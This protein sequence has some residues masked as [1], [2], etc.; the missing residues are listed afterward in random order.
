MIETLQPVLILL[1]CGI[2]SVLLLPRIGVSPIVGFLVAGMVLGH[3]G[4]GLIPHND[5]IHLLAE[6]GVVFLLFDIGLHFSLRH[7]KQE[8]KGIFLLGPLQVFITAG[9]FYLIG[10]A[11]SLPSDVNLVMSIALALSSTAVVSQVLKDRGIEGTPNSNTA[12]AILVFQDICAIFLLILAD[13]IGG[14]GGME[15]AVE[16]GAAVIK[17]ILCFFAALFIGKYILNPF[18]GRLIRFNNSEVF[19][20][21]ALFL[22]LLTGTATGAIGLSLTLGAFLAGMIISETPFKHIIQTELRPF[23]FLLLSFFFLTVGALIDIHI[24]IEQW[25]MVLAATAVLV[26]V[27]FGAIF[28][29]FKVLRG[30]T[31]NAILQSTLLFQGSEF[32]FVV[33]AAPAVAAALDSTMI[34]VL[35]AAVAL[36]MALTT[37]VYDWFA[38]HICPYVV[39]RE[40][41]KKAADTQEQE[42]AQE[43]PSMI[44][45]G[46]DDAGHTLARALHHFEIPYIA[47]DQEYRNFLKARLGGFSVL[48]GDKADV[49]FWENLGIHNYQYL[50]ISAPNMQLAQLYEPIARER[51]PHLIRHVVVFDQSDYDEYVEKTTIM[52]TMTYGVPPGLELAEKVLHDIGVDCEEIVSWMAKEQKLHLDKSKPN[53]GRVDIPE[54]LQEQAA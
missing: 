9:I 38:K 5:T 16:T 18:F 53:K 42:Q 48:Y 12:M 41:A 25:Y 22:V 30:R 51:F 8:W 50:L 1:G 7:I 32:L 3:H 13:S 49:R 17:C 45:L 40:N 21:I 36:S 31:S 10:M 33:I 26:I 27:K 39:S 46:M 54:D 35:I 43:K 4:M 2:V 44:V 37:F 52:P 34:S 19:T 28:G 20:M 14:A 24:L 15:L 29:M 11:L 47:V 6:L 23:R